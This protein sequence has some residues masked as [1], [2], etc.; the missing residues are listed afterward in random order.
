MSFTGKLFN[1]QFPAS[2]AEK[3]GSTIPFL[4]FSD[5]GKNDAL[6][7]KTSQPK[8]ILIVHVRLK[9]DDGGFNTIQ[10]IIER[11]YKK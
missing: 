8:A 4:I 3:K 9:W 2:P 5:V 11:T 10:Y 7:S 6:N 1:N